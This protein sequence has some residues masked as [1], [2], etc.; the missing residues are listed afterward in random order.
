MSKQMD[1]FEQAKKDE[2]IQQK[3]G[4]RTLGE[5]V[6]IDGEIREITYLGQQKGNLVYV[7]LRNADGQSLG[8]WL[9]A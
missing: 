4:R 7:R 8:R 3:V 6:T 2:A 5:R 9:S 1:M